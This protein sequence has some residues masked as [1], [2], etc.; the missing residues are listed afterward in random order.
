VRIMDGCR[1]WKAWT[2]AS[3]AHIVGVR[4]YRWKCSAVLAKFSGRLLRSSSVRVAKYSA[5]C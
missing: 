4:E 3:V 1:F 2:C 5:W